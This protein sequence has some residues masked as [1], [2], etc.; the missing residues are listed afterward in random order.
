[1]ATTRLPGEFS[2]LS[3]T[4]NSDLGGDTTVHGNLTVGNSTASVRKTL[5]VTGNLT[6]NAIQVSSFSVDSNLGD[7]DQALPTQNAVKTYV[8]GKLSL[9]ADTTYVNDKLSTKADTTYV[10]DGLNAT[11]ASGG[12]ETQDFKAKAL[13]VKEG[14]IFK[15]IA[16]G[17]NPPGDPLPF[18][19]PYETI[20]TINKTHNL[21]FYT[22]SAFFHTGHKSEPTASIDRNGNL[23]VTGNLTVN[24]N[25]G[26]GTTNPTERLEVQGNMKVN[27]TI[28]DVNGA[29]IPKGTI[30]MWT[31]DSIPEGWVLCNGQNGTPDLRGRFIVGAGA[32]DD[33][34]PTYKSGDKG[35]PD[36]HFHT[37]NVP[38]KNIST[39]STGQ[40]NHSFPSRW[41]A[42]NDFDT[43]TVLHGKTGIDTCGSYNETK[44]TQDAGNHQHSVEIRDFDS[45]LNSGPNRPKWYALCFIMKL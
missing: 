16:V 10:N 13:T 44:N 17:T 1:M 38:S 42:R 14:G 12:S 37:I 30:V 27:G 29:I 26:I 2:T 8:D 35:D 4:N 39:S 25:V 43:T 32:G 6:L 19:W 24:G 15:G 21:R 7:S 28:S 40:H 22:N 18:P 31:G 45:K 33:V 34:S 5:S 11:A 36:S 9:K 20:S 3:V 41:Y 23:S